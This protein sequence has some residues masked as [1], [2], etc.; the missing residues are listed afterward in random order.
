MEWI[1][2]DIKEIAAFYPETNRLQLL[3]ADPF[4]LG[5]ERLNEICD[6]IHNICQILKS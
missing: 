3:S 4:V 2:E 1:E 5:F 6:L